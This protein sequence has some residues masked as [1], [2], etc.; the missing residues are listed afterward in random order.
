MISRRSFLAALSCLPLVGKM[1]PQAKV[2][3]Y[4]VVPI[5]LGNQSGV[6]YDALNW[7]IIESYSTIDRT[8]CKFH[9]KDG[10]RTETHTA[11]CDCRGRSYFVKVE[12][13]QKYQA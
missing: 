9:M 4:G 2:I 3:D 6:T 13:D 5:Q 1:I 10:V 8:G 11:A 7:R 12:W